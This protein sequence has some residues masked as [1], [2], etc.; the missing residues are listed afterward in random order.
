MVLFELKILEVLGA[1]GCSKFSHISYFLISILLFYFF[2]FFLFF[3]LA[4]GTKITT[5]WCVLL[6]HIEISY[7]ISQT[8]TTSPFDN[9][10]HTHHK[11][12]LIWKV[13]NGMY[14]WVTKNFEP[15]RQRNTHTAKMLHIQVHNENNNDITHCFK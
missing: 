9:V 3:F 6:S 14:V 13:Q 4:V 2:F 8:W 1:A 15:F 7:C 11:T 10:T 12:I 5:W